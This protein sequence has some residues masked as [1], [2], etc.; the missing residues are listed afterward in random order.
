[1]SRSDIY[2]LTSNRF[3]SQN[4]F[5]SLESPL[6]GDCKSVTELRISRTGVTWGQVSVLTDVLILADLVEPLAILGV[7]FTE[8]A[9][10]WI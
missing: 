3:I 7:F 2:A 9:G 6:V 1:M 4:I 8:V 5:R 10:T